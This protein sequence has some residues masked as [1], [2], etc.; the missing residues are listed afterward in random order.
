MGSSAL[1]KLLL[2]AQTIP[3]ATAQAGGWRDGGGLLAQVLTKYLG[4]RYSAYALLCCV[5]YAIHYS[6]TLL[7]ETCL[8][9][10]FFS[11]P[12]TQNTTSHPSQDAAYILCT[13]ITL[14]ACL[15]HVSS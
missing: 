12:C 14:V 3:H 5:H 11:I 10:R 13:Y 7:H 15:S 2:S 8:V 4:T 6:S 9:Q 1:R